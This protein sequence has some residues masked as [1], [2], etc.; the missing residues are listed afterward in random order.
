MPFPKLAA[1]YSKGFLPGDW[2]FFRE[3]AE[4]ILK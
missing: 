1:G 4:Y 2:A 3:N